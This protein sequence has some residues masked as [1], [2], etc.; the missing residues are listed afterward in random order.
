MDTFNFLLYF[1][2]VSQHCEFQGVETTPNV[3]FCH[4]C[5]YSEAIFNFSIGIE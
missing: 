2:F 5:F 3:I 4:R 1:H